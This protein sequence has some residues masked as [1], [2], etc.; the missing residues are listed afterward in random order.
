MIISLLSNLNLPL[1]RHDQSTDENGY[2][3]KSIV[4][5]AFEQAR[6]QCLANLS[7]MKSFT[8][9]NGVT[10]MLKANGKGTP[11]AVKP[12]PQTLE[13]AVETL[14]ATTDRTTVA[15]PREDAIT[16]GTNRGSQSDALDSEEEKQSRESKRADLRDQRVAASTAKRLVHFISDMAKDPEEV[17]IQVIQRCFLDS[18]LQDFLFEAELTL[19]M[20]EVVMSNAKRQTDTAARPGSHRHSILTIREANFTQKR[21]IQYYTTVLQ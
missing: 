18:T 9:A 5:D 12:T 20:R 15:K 8:A 7:A 10:G 21:S 11:D 1:K 14:S 3:F 2:E 17:Q 6:N 4:E 19:H 16:K 13:S